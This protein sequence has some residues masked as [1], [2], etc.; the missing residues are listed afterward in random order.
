MLPFVD[1]L[2]PSIIL[3]PRGPWST[4]QVSGSFLS[5]AGHPQILPQLIHALNTGHITLASLIHA[6]KRQNLVF[7]LLIETATELV[8][9]TDHVRSFPIYFSHN[10]N[11]LVLGSSA[12][13]VSDKG[14][15]AILSRSAVREYLLSGYVHSNRTLYKD[16]FSLP[17]G[18]ILYFDKR[19]QVLSTNV[20]FQY[21][22]QGTA[23]GARQ[24]LIRAF[25]ETLD[26]I[27]EEIVANAYGRPIWLPLSGGLDSRLILCK[28]LEHGAKD[29]TTFTYGNRQNHEIG[30]AK[31]ISS[32][33]N[34]RW[35]EL[36]SRPR[37][38]QSL[39]ASTVRHEYADY[40]DGLH[41]TPVY[42]DFEA[43][44]NLHS[45]RRIPSDAILINGYSGDFLFGGHIP[46][47][48]AFCPSQDL[49]VDLFIKKNVSNFNTQH[50]LAAQKLVRSRLLSRARELQKDSSSAANVTG[51]YEYLD[52][53]ER[54]TK[55]VVNGQRLYEFFGYEWEL[56][57]WD[58]RLLDLWGSI[59]VHEKLNQMLHLR[60]LK[61][62]NYRDA[63]SS[64]RSTNQ[65]WPTRWR[66]IPAIGALLGLVQGTEQKLQYYEKMFFRS[67]FNYQLSLFGKKAYQNWYRSLRTPRVIPLA[68]MTR[69]EEL[70]IDPEEFLS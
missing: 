35:L 4:E 54:Q 25:G 42:L 24:Q 49:A 1:Q 31:T 47:S 12:R 63:F 70:Q 2:K 50:L 19:S 21:L 16:L 52:W 36:V 68:S 26:E 23:L 61:D 32:R 33:L 29:I 60:Y 15:S 18:H 10:Q 43:I 34:V 11:S 17:A 27:F 6:L 57:L 39:Y 28:L 8:A 64:L 53:S 45:N 13:A 41:M 51:F 37:K 5:H 3:D 66:W 38:A 20:Y 65:I 48:L 56:P 44:E 9:V 62:Y 67:Y 7:G 14:K 69:L 40:S 46:E 30:M 22:P 55:S 58:R 59:P